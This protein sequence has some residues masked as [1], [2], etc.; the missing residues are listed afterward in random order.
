MRD[1]SRAPG[2]QDRVRGSGSSSIGSPVSKSELWFFE[3]FTV[4]KSYSRFGKPGILRLLGYVKSIT[5][6]N[7]HVTPIPTRSTIFNKLD[8]PLPSHGKGP[9]AISF[10]GRNAPR[11]SRFKTPGNEL[12]A[13]PVSP[14][15]GCDVWRNRDSA[16][17]AGLA[18][19]ALTFGGYS[20]HIVP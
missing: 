9:Q 12:S 17:T 1:R 13:L 6:I 20:Q 7:T 2:F 11:A 16:Q 14:L 8:K 4:Q 10:V 18:A 19:L 5:V 15:N 3:S